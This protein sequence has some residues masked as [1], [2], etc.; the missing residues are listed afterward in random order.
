M[1]SEFLTATTP[2]FMAGNNKVVLYGCLMGIALALLLLAKTKKRG[3][4]AIQPSTADLEKPG[5]KRTQSFKVSVRHPGEWT[6]MHF[7]R[8]IASPLLQWN[9]YETQPLPYRPFKYGPYHIT[10]GL[11][12]MQWDEWIELD[13]HFLKFHADKALRIEERGDK[14]CRTAPEAMDGALELLEEL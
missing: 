1:S 6:P 14:C 8:P 13:N 5:V 2:G 11:R 7:Q 4:L 3:K 12:A 9:V 10:M